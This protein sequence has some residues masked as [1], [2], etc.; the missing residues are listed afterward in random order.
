MAIDELEAEF[1]GFNSVASL[2]L[3]NVASMFVESCTDLTLSV[4]G[5]KGTE[6]KSDFL[7]PLTFE[8]AQW[9]VCLLSGA[10]SALLSLCDTLMSWPANESPKQAEAT[11]N[12]GCCNRRQVEMDCCA[13]GPQLTPWDFGLQLARQINPDNFCWVRLQKPFCVF[14]LCLSLTARLFFFFFPQDVPDKRGSC[15]GWGPDWLA[16]SEVCGER[17]S[18]GPFLRHR[19]VT[20]V[21]SNWSTMVLGMNW[22]SFIQYHCFDFNLLA[23]VS[24]QLNILSLLRFAVV[25]GYAAFSFTLL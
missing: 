6:R 2:W 22:F 14:H 5:E 23:V 1:P 13:Q 10:P 4:W 9:V 16:I 15:G 19:Y 20:V 25:W 7:L 8:R 3:T 12:T 11:A 24:F 17:R 21:K 18:T